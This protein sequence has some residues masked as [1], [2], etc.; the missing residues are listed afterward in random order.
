MASDLVESALL[1]LHAAFS[2]RPTLDLISDASRLI[3][4]AKG[5]LAI[6]KT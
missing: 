5:K 6:L 4:S 2:G 3:L 1:D